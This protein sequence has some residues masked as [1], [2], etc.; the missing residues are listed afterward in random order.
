MGKLMRS[1][2]VNWRVETHREEKALEIL[3][4]PER[5]GEDGEAGTVGTV[6]LLSDGVM[7]QLNLIGGEIWKLCDGSRD[8]NGILN[9]LLQ[10]FAADRQT[11]KE[12]LDE[13]LSDMINRGLIHECEER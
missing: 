10:I 13:F 4:D 2:S 8:R 7:H 11:V 5:E 6:T 3:L 9:S 1:P 12:D